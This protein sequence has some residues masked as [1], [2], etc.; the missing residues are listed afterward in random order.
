MGRSNPLGVFTAANPNVGWDASSS[1]ERLIDRSV[2]L[3]HAS[4]GFDVHRDIP[5]RKS[6]AE[7]SFDFVRDRVGF[8]GG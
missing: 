4:V 8:R 6:L 1:F 2:P 7:D 5:R 3:E